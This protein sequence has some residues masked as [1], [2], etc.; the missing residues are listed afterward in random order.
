MTMIFQFVNGMGE[1]REEVNLICNFTVGGELLISL[2]Y[3]ALCISFL[4]FFPFISDF[5]LYYILVL[6]NSLIKSI[7]KMK[8]L[9][10]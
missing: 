7:F 6:K 3:I 1:P 8:I 10:C 5:S 2:I 9:V 4:S